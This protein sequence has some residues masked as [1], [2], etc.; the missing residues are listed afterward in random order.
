LKECIKSD[1]IK[2]FD[3]NGDLKSEDNTQKLQEEEEKLSVYKE[4]KDDLGSL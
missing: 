3:T 4:R 2:V 1:A